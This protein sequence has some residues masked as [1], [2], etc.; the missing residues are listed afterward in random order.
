MR[1][2]RKGNGDWRLAQRHQRPPATKDE[3]R[4]AWR[5][6][7]YRDNTRQ[8]CLCEQFGLCAFSEIV[9]NESDLGM[10]L[11]HVEPKSKN[12]SRTFDHG[13]LVLSAIADTKLSSLAKQNVFGGNYR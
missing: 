13:N 7:D 4:K 8:I 9:L 2:I 6:F 10:H 11:D 5:R 12:P 1:H 3:A